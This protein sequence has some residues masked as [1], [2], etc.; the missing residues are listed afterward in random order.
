VALTGAT[1]VVYGIRLLEVLQGFTD[2]ETH[3][4]ISE[5]AEEVINLETD[6]EVGEVKKLAHYHHE[7]RDLAA[8]L[9]SGSFTTRGMVVAPCSMKT[10]A[11]IAHGLADNLITRAADVTLKEKRKLILAPRETPL[12]VIHLENMVTLARVGAILMPPMPA[13]YNLPRDIND[14]VDHFVGRILDQFDLPHELTKPWQGRNT[15]G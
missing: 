1:G 6:R 14:L 3:L 8:S 13:F 11:A 7:F 10:M 4:I 9:A 12:N 2:V 15:G 5:Y